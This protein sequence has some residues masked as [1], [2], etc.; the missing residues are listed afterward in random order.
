MER[1][2]PEDWLPVHLTRP[3]WLD[4][5]EDAE[6]LAWTEFEGYRLPMDDREATPSTYNEWHKAASY[7]GTTNTIYGFGRNTITGADGNYFGS[8]DP[9]D[10]EW[11]PGSNT[12]SSSYLA[13]TPVGF[14]DG[15]LQLKGD[16]CWPDTDPNL[17]SFQTNPNENAWG[18]FDLSGASWKWTADKAVGVED[19][20]L[21][22]SIRGGS[23]ISS[24][25]TCQVTVQG[26]MPPIRSNNPDNAQVSFHVVRVPG[27]APFCGQSGT[28]YLDADT[29]GPGG[30]PDCYVDMYDLQDFLSRW[31]I[32]DNL[33][34]FATLSEQWM[35]CTDPA[36][37]SCP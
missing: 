8:G 25:A 21:A 31:L 10:G 37:A 26:H 9:W 13:V 15:S 2:T 3:E 27:G 16:W 7:T 14:Y 6:R 11:V 34:Q 30:E 18:I 12:P 4:G 35:L 17:V 1:S 22:V 33:V 20:N 29:S 36:N 23:N 28:V 5:F 19:P 24:T 32:V